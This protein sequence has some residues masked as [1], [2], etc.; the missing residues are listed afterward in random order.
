MEKA[1]GNAQPMLIDEFTQALLYQSTASQGASVNTLTLRFR[2]RAV[3]TPSGVLGQDVLVLSNMT[4]A[5][6]TSSSNLIIGDEGTGSLKLLGTSGS[7]TKET[8][9]IN[10]I[11][12]APSCLVDFFFY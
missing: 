12:F 11:A 5:T 3:L 8:L 7:W 4:G 10:N 9:R 6:T 1:A 2:T